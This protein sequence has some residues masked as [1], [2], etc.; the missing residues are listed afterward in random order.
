MRSLVY[1]KTRELV[2]ELLEWELGGGQGYSHS[3]H[4]LTPTWQ[5]FDGQLT[6]NQSTAEAMMAQPSRC[7]LPSA[8]V[9][10]LWGDNYARHLGT[11]A[12]AGRDSTQQLALSLANYEWIEARRVAVDGIASALE[13]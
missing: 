11:G 8:A 3:R 10:Q 2:P 6:D 5:R 13:H 9:P 7:P 4:P 12:E 1:N